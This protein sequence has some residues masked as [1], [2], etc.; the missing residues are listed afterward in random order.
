MIQKLTILTAL[1][2]LVGASGIGSAQ[3]VD[4]AAS[5]VGYWKLDGDTLDSSGLENHA[6]AMGNPVFEAGQSSVFKEA[7]YFDGDGDYLVMDSVADDLTD[8]DVT[9][10]AWVKTDDPGTW[11]WWFSCNTSAGGN[12]VLLGLISGQVIVY[13]I[14]AQ[15]GSSNTVINDSE[16]YH[17]AYSRIG[18]V[19]TL[20]INGVSEVTHSASYTFSADD[21]WS[22]AQEW[23][24]GGPSDFLDATIDDVRIYDRGLTEEELPLIMAPQPGLA[25]EPSPANGAID[26]LRDSVVSWTPGEY[27]STHD[28]YFGTSFDDVNAASQDVPLGV[29]ASQ[30]QSD[31]TYDPGRLEFGQIY[32]WRIDEVN[33][34][35]DYSIYTG[36]IW[37]FTVE[38]E[39]Y[40]IEGVVATTNGTAAMGQDI[41]NIVN[42]SGLDADDLHSYD[43]AQMWLADPAADGTLWVQF[44]FGTIYKLH[45]AVIWNYNVQFETVLGFGAKDVTV[46]YSADG[47]DWTVLG[48]VVVGQGIGAG[49]YAANTTI[50]FGG[51]AVKFVRFNINS[52]FGT[53]GQYGLSEVRFLYIPALATEPEP[54]DGAT[55]VSVGSSLSWKAGRGVGSHEVSLGTDPEDLPVVASLQDSVYESPE[56]YLG[57]TYYWQVVEVNDPEAWA[58]DV[59]TFSTE[60]YVVID[61]FESYEGDAEAIAAGEAVWQSWLDGIEDSANGGSQVGHD[62]EPYVEQTIVHGGS[63]SMPLHYNNADYSYSEATKTFDTA[64]DWTAHGIE[65]LTVFFRGQEAN[66]GQLYVKIN[67]V[68]VPYDGAADNITKITWT[69]WNID[70][71][72]V[73]T[74]LAGVQTLAIG[75]EGSGATGTLLIDDIRLY[76]E[77]PIAPVE[78]DS[79][80][81]VAHYAFDGDATDSSGNGHNGEI[82]GGAT[83][84][85]GII[86]QA[87]DLDGVD[88]FVRIADADAL[89]P[90]T[91]S[92]SFTFWAQLDRAS[93]G[94]GT[95]VWDLAVNRRQ[96]G[97]NGYYIGANR[98]QGGTEEAGYKFMLGNTSASR[99]D[100]G[101]MVVPLGEWVFVAAVLDR[102]ENVH[103][104]SVNGG[105][106]W[107]AATPPTGSIS[108]TQ[109][110]AIGFDIG[111]DDYWFHGLIDQVRLYNTALTD[112]EVA[113]LA[114]DL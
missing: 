68:K 69:T 48:D 60:E 17:V 27:A 113:W 31:S 67:G 98:D 2:L 107:A 95:A 47:V 40:P 50:D 73:G 12:V 63:Q 101:Y 74:N 30:G 59:W 72:G 24:A 3:V 87:I 16:W 19:G 28:V 38:P 111:P 83:F 76:Q 70:L 77:P 84:V 58:A 32:Y 44:D 112:A 22:I 56:L 46:E 33:G 96:T 61:D 64:L 36:K 88:N 21:R 37:S 66:T 20:Y 14:T 29:L 13:E 80:N 75:M 7:M 106:S 71:A 8:D 82:Q 62:T 18:S 81:L 79:A 105:G 103:K 94:S 104:I 97:S 15:E 25:S 10:S 1:A 65:A 9:M 86:G 53:Q 51:A 110:L 26:V 34:A 49:G 23:D 6:T 100:T 11:Q 35:P 89:N 114:S 108:P 109:D 92:Y 91:G 41:E 99:V 55:E 102:D 43:G 57:T 90:G 45:Q 54:A 85:D 78:P 4:P 42:G 39:G 5:L 52:G 93:S